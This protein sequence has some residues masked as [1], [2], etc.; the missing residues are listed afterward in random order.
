MALKV[1]AAK[2]PAGPISA[3]EPSNRSLLLALL[4]I[5]LSLLLASLDQ[6]IVGTAM[7]RIVEELQGFSLYSW[8][9]TIYLL[10]STAVIPIAGKLGDMFG[11]KWVLLSAVIIFL[12]GSALCG[13]A[14]SMLWLVIF[15]GLQGVGGGALMSNAFASVSDIF[16]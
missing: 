7:P 4:G 6:T 2:Q 5:I 3:G 11:R 13:A 1:S 16:P 8:V 12:L 9:T 10:T 14:P 15:R